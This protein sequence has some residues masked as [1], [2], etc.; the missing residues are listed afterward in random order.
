[1]REI[2]VDQITEAVAQMVQ[3]ANT[4]LEPDVVA[5][6]ARAAQD[7]KSSVG[8]G[9]LLQIVENYKIAET[10]FIPMCQD[11][12]VTVCFVDVGQDVHIVGGTLRDAINRGVARGY[13]EGFLRKS[14]LTDPLTRS[15]NSGDNTPAIIHTELVAGDRLKIVVDCKGG[16][17]ENMSRLV[18]LKP[19]DG[20]EGVKQFVIDTVAAAGPNA[21]PP[22]IVGVGVGGNFETCARLAKRSLIR[23]VGEPNTDPQLAALEA[24]LLQ[25]INSLGVGPMGLGGTVTAL[26]VHVETHPCHIVSLPV[27]V[28]IECHS[29]R[30]KEVVL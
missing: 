3:E 4:K 16:G 1:M 19:S 20:I 29:H 28:N 7:E 24:E 5:A 18:M 12:G 26:A 11:T 10:E 8:Q 15:H 27:A 13:T 25:A 23:H 2:H 6:L 9:V 30:H 21:C 14:M 22:L 17:S